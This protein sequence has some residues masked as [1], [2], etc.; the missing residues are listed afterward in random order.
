MPK[1]VFV[2]F[3]NL[4]SD[5]D[6]SIEAAALQTRHKFLGVIPL[7]HAFGMTAMML[8]PIQL[9]ST[10][11]YMARFSPA[12]TGSDPGARHL[13]DVWRAEHV[14]RHRPTQGCQAGRFL[15]HVRD[16]RRR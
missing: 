12:C 1:G 8:A 16:D 4:Q 11:I 5:I 3:G 7:F 9:G 13:A 15:E 2:S 14:R 6:A 10:V